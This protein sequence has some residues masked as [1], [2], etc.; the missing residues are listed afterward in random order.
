MS[1]IERDCEGTPADSSRRKFIKSAAAAVAAGS[2][3]TLLSPKLF[4]QAREAIKIGFIV[5]LT[6]PYSVEAQ[7]QVK[8]AELAIKEF[9]DAGGLKGRMAELLV[10][11]D[12]LNPGEGATRALELIEKDKVK[13][14]VGSLS[15]SVQLSINNVTKQRGVIFVSISQSDAINEAKDWSPYT[16]HEALNPHMTGGAL[17]RYVF[18]RYGKRA[19]ILAYDAVFGAEMARAWQTAAKPL[20]VEFAETIK[21]PIGQADYSA[22][23]PRILAAKPDVLMVASFGRDQL[24]VMKQAT[25]FG[26]KKQLR[27]VVAP[28][29][30]SARAIG[31][32]EAFKDVIGAAN[33]YWALE[34]TEKSAKV[35]N[36]KF[37]AMH[38]SVPSD[39]GAYAY[40]GVRQVLE[41]IKLTNDGGN[42]KMIEALRGLKYDYYK[43]PQYYRRCDHQSVQSVLIVESIDKS[44]AKHEADT[45]RIL[46]IE[47]PDEMRLRTCAELGLKT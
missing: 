36:D 20:G 32:H 4:A 12:K 24:N 3:A 2:T 7:G 19:I 27:I 14:V 35:F 31:G 37:R 39:Y 25:D 6:G 45:M 21:H 34:D 13:V 15:A 43:G 47:K 11:D 41:A 33:Y 16:F 40:S 8:G 46:A 1:A 42:D 28:M 29:S 44:Q 10:R 23:F 5:P 22:Y 26:L 17:A 18:P 38:K 30:F 9:N